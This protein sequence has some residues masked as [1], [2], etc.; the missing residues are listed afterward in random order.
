MPN[1]VDVIEHTTEYKT[2]EFK[3]GRV[4]RGARELKF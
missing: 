1:T 4:S 3:A 2:L